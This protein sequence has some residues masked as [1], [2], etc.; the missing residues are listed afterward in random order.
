MNP[1]TDLDNMQGGGEAY[2]G[3]NDDE[4]SDGN[5]IPTVLGDLQVIIARDNYKVHIRKG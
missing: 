1:D 3:V 4:I 5:E 2:T